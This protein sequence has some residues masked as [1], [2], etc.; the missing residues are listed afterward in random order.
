MSTSLHA[1]TSDDFFASHFSR[2]R[3]M[4]IFRGFTPEQTAALCRNAFDAG[5]TLVEVPLTGEN[6]IAALEAAVDVARGRRGVSVGAGTVILAEQVHTVIETGGDFTVAPGVHPAAIEA[7]REANLPHLPGVA[8]S[9]DIAYALSYGYT[10]QKVFPAAQ[11]GADW[12]TA[13]HGP[14][15]HVKFVATGGITPGNTTSFFKAGIAGVAWGSAF[16]DSTAL[17]ELASLIGMR[18]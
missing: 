11:L 5:I 1:T 8:T 7:S 14:F 10:W 15:P 17:E 12:V 4:G 9:S 16:S 18:P 3:V 13:Q 2:S 6:S